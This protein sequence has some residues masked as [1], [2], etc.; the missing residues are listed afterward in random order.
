MGIKVDF[1]F[2]W[3]VCSVLEEEHKAKKKRFNSGDE[4]KPSEKEHTP[5]ERRLLKSNTGGES[6]VSQAFVYEGTIP[7][8][9]YSGKCFIPVGPY[10]VKLK[11]ALEKVTEPQPGGRPGPSSAGCKRP[12]PEGYRWIAAT[13][14]SEMS[15]ALV[16]TKNSFCLII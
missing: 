4:H 9:D 10:D 11:P 1:E 3:I 12:A 7:I 8:Y 6:K 14:D 15:H 5:K 16:R 2:P 13:R